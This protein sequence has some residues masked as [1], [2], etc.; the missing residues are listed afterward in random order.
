V[1]KFSAI[2]AILAVFGAAAAEAGPRARPVS[3]EPLHFRVEI[4]GRA[5]VSFAGWFD[6]GRGTGRGYDVVALDLDG[7]GR[8]ESVTDLRN[9]R[10]T[11]RTTDVGAGAFEVRKGG[12]VYVLEFHELLRRRPVGKTIHTVLR[13]SVEKDGTHAWFSSGRVRLHRTA[14]AARAA[15]PILLGGPLRLRTGVE[16]RGTETLLRLEVLDRSGCGLKGLWRGDREIR[17]E[18]RLLSGGVERLFARTE[19]G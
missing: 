8:P 10:I 13:W 17:P 2:L 16:V 7:D 12:A 1:A 3:G 14:A 15:S 19:Y 5:P 4:G 6:E 9:P 18:V 11:G